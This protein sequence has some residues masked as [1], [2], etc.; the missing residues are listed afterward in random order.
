MDTVIKADCIVL[1]GFSE[2]PMSKYAGPFRIA[3]ELRLNGYTVHCIDISAYTHHFADLVSLLKAMIGDN[4]LWVGLS[5]TFYSGPDSSKF[6][7]R[8][9]ESVNLINSNVKFIAGGPRVDEIKHFDIKLFLGY[10]DSEIVEFTDWCSKINKNLKFH[11]RIIHGTEFDKFCDSQ[12]SYT[13]TDLVTSTDVLP[14]EVS[15]GCIFK[16]KFCSYMLNG[17]T[18]GDWIKKPSV[19]LEELTN[20]YTQWGVTDYIFSDDTYN[21]SLEKI[22]TLH[23][24]VFS[25]LPFK[26]NF[27][28]YLRLD[29][30]MRYPDM[31]KYL[32]AS[33]LQN[34]IF[35]IESINHQSAKSIGKGVN[36][37]EQFDF[38]R[39]LKKSEFSEINTHSGFILGLPHDTED[40]CIETREFLLSDKNPLDS[41][42]VQRLH[43]NVKIEGRL[44]AQYSEFDLNYSDYGYKVSDNSWINDVTNLSSD[45]AERY[46]TDISTKA[47]G[48]FKVP[49]FLHPYYRGLGIEHKELN[50]LTHME[51]THTHRVSLLQYR[52]KESYRLRLKNLFK[53]G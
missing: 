33:G 24:E 28:S 34:A 38:L 2:R 48:T 12:I 31:A 44:R 39:D 5:T 41:F 49:G 51:V 6:L 1:Y 50:A 40:T 23:D 4:T 3:T 11:D 30:I 36:P 46:S 18:K 21:D 10:S 45:I 9:I 53:I 26:L 42:S 17:K 7:G 35:G 22:I 32:K 19:L 20:N 14:I 13:D 15:R 25:K 29:L 37:K 8:I 16:C 52:K 43:L 47:F 27:T